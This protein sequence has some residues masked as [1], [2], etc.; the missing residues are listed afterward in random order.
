MKKTMILV[1]AIVLSAVSVSA[2][3]NDCTESNVCLLGNNSMACFMTNVSNL[4][5][6]EIQQL[7]NFCWNFNASGCAGM[8]SLI[9]EAAQDNE[10]I[11]DTGCPDGACVETESQPL[12]TISCYDWNGDGSCIEVHYPNGGEVFAHGEVVQITL[13]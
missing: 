11:I 4:A 8:Q 13:N 12:E 6:S 2:L 7:Q 3:T 9:D 5:F 10:C 1:L